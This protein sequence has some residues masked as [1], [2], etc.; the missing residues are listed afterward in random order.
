M[1]NFSLFFIDFNKIPIYDPKREHNCYYLD[2]VFFNKKT[3]VLKE[4]IN[5]VNILFL[6]LLIKFLG[7]LHV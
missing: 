3:T 7:G 1:S 2:V 5:K 6:N 4:F